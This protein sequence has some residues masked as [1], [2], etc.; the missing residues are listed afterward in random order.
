MERTEP[1]D[2]D[3]VISRRPEVNGGHGSLQI[4]AALFSMGGKYGEV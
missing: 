2:N 3:K 4:E 1:Q